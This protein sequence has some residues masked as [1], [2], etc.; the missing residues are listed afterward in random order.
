M[1][2]GFWAIAVKDLR[3][4]FMSPLIYVIGGVCA[5]LW[6]LVFGIGVDQF[7][8][9]SVSQMIQAMQGDASQTLNLHRML[10]AYHV[11]VA[12][13]VMVIA[14]SALSMK[15]LSEEKKQRTFDLLLTS[16]VTA[17]DIAVGKLL[18]GTLAAWA[19]CFLNMAYP[20]SLLIFSKL[21]WGPLASAYL[22]LILLSCVYVSI[23]LFA[24][25]LTESSVLAVIIAILG[26]FMLF[27]IS[28]PAQSVESQFAKAV[29]EQLNVGNHLQE[30]VGATVSLSGLAFFFSVIALFTLLTQRV[31]ESAR[32]R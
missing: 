14:C 23:G 22:G 13:L 4:Y 28:S 30:F 11:S 12:N 25:S 1:T 18:A 10:I 5:V 7:V 20:L 19:L 2:K 9:A 16:P 24:S 21:E 15:L 32:W 17:T 27:F 8:G 6:S 31:I 3:G 26:N 29:F